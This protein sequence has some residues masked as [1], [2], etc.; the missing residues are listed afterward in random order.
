MSKKWADILKD[1]QNYPDDYVISMKD[2]STL[3]LG[4]ARSYDRENEGRL[5]QTLTAKERELQEKEGKLGMAANEI[6]SLFQQ[7]SEMTGLSPEEI[8]AGKKPTT[9]SV[10]ATHNLDE[11]DPLVGELVKEVKSLKSALD[12]TKSE[13]T[14]LRDKGVKPIVGQYMNDWYEMK[15]EKIVPTLPKSA[16]EK[17][18]MKALM[19]YA[20]K[21]RLTDASGRLDLSK[22]AREMFEE[23][24]ISERVEAKLK[25]ERKKQAEIETLRAAQPPVREGSPKLGVP[26]S[27]KNEKGQTKS[28]DEV[29]QEAATDSALWTGIAQGA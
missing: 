6:A 10:A 26:K 13:I 18:D 8:L 23:D 20:E 4:D 1:S 11:N 2:G 16:R 3:S 17:A 25:D 12:A 28:F 27:F 21:N 7:Y 14:T 24:F 15:Y 9:R 5:T 22:A 19:G 29:L